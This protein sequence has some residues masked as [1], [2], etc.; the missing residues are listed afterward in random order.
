MRLVPLTS[1]RLPNY[2]LETVAEKL[3][4]AAL[5]IATAPCADAVMTAEVFLALMPLAAGNRRK[6][7]CRSGARLPAD[8]RRISQP[9]RRH[10]H[11]PSPLIWQISTVFHFAGASAISCRTRLQS[12]MPGRPCRPPSP[13][14][15]EKRISS[16]F[17]RS[18]GGAANS[19]HYRLPISFGPLTATAAPR[20]ANPWMSSV[21]VPLLTVRADEF[22]YRAIVEMADKTDQPSRCR[23]R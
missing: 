19:N 3:R 8:L 13:Q 6:F 4:R 20:S 12:P 21:P 10:R 5:K 17:V 16:L 2:G 7:V 15:V 14:M 11:S 1:L 22:V 9:L 18:P 23:R